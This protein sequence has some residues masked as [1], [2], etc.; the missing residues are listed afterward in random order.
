VTDETA[1]TSDLLRSIE[2][3]FQRLKKLFR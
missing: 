3:L 2:G 1:G